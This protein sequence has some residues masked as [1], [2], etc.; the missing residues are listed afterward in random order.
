MVT[1]KMTVDTTG[2]W[3]VARSVCNLIHIAEDDQKGTSDWT[4]QAPDATS[5]ILTVPA[6]QARDIPT[7][8]LFQ[9]GEK[10]AL[11]A[12]LVGTMNFTWSEHL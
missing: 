10:I 6:G 1:G 2:E 5:P 9:P 8:T 4:M 3:L 11:L 12:S 7:K